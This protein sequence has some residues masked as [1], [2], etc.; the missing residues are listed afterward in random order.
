[1]LVNSFHGYMQSKQH[2]IYDVKTSISIEE[3]IRN[4]KVANVG[5]NVTKIF[6]HL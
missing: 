4:R 3:N 6:E 1:M 5:K 2:F